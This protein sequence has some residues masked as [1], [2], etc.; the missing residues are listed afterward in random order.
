[1]TVIPAMES[2]ACERHGL[3]AKG[4]KLEQAIRINLWGLGYGG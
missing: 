4:E 2:C 3:F 1:M